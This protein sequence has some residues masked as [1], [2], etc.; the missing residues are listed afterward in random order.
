LDGYLI[1]A[2][3]LLL[4]VVA[5]PVLVSEGQKQT[6][7]GKVF[8][9]IVERARASGMT[10][11]QIV[12]AAVAK[13]VPAWIILWARKNCVVATGPRTDLSTTGLA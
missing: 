5:T 3:A 6:S 1:A 11:K 12:E 13:H 9:P 7:L 8:C 2:A 10:D 4:A